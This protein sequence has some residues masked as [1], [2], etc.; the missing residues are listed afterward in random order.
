MELVYHEQIMTLEV[1]ENIRRVCKRI[2]GVWQE[3]QWA[4]KKGES[5]V[6]VIELDTITHLEEI[7]WAE[8]QRWLDAMAKSK[9]CFVVYKNNPQQTRAIQ[10]HMDIA[11][12][13]KHNV[14]VLTKEVK[15]LKELNAGLERKYKKLDKEYYTKLVPTENDL[16]E[17]LAK[18]RDLSKG[19]NILRDQI[20]NLQERL[21]SAEAII[22]NK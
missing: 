12:S 11:A 6:A 22:K 9:D 17:A 18:A 8:K 1:A 19:N 3:G 13:A 14:E 4:L 15:F 20:Y 7:Y 5:W 16:E 2:N 10:E 21:R